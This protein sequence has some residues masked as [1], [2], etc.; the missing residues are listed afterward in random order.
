MAAPDKGMKFYKAVAGCFERLARQKG[1]TNTDGSIYLVSLTNL[2]H[3]IALQEK[4]VKPQSLK[5]Y[6]SALREKHEQLGFLE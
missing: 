4:R 1:W 6:L 5:S 3:Y 2:Q